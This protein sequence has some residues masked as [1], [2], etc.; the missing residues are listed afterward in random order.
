MSC[1]A[2]SNARFSCLSTG[3]VL[4]GV[5]FV[6][7]GEL[8]FFSTANG[9]V[10]SL[11]LRNNTGMPGTSRRWLPRSFL[12]R[13]EMRTEKNLRGLWFRND[14]T[15]QRTQGIKRVL[16]TLVFFDVVRRVE[17]KFLHPRE[18]GPFGFSNSL[19]HF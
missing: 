12:A 18:N 9:N 19:G 11:A 2:L 14:A 13:G 10:R 7:R 1:T 17:E 4:S 3:M 15:A 16:E 6:I 8:D 5:L